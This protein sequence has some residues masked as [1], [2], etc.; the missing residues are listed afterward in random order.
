MIFSLKPGEIGQPFRSA[1]GFHIFALEEWIPAHDQKFYEVRDQI[2]DLLIAEKER[3]RVE[4]YTDQLMQ[5]A[6]LRVSDPDLSLET[7]ENRPNETTVE[8]P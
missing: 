7:V 4:A 1:H 2:F 8:Q 6:S 5:N 3:E